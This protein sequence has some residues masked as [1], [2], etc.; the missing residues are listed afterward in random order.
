[1]GTPPCPLN[2][3]CLELTGIANKTCVST[4]INNSLAVVGADPTSPLANNGGGQVLELALAEAA[5]IYGSPAN[6]SLSWHYGPLSQ[7]LRYRCKSI[8]YPS[9]SDGKVE[10]ELGRGGGGQHLIFSLMVTLL[11]PTYFEETTV[12]SVL[13]LGDAGKFSFP[14]PNITKGSLC[15]YTACDATRASAQA[16]PNAGDPFHPSSHT[17]LAHTNT[18]VTVR[19]ETHSNA[20]HTNTQQ[21]PTCSPIPTQV[22]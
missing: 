4:A 22:T 1:M 19:A 6:A 2:Y 5:T 11:A 15:K 9:I 13:S 8:S 12:S 16:D 20:P 18:V 3:T 17:P 7:P 14:V 10:C 21:S